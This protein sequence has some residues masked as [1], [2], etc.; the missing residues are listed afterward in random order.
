MLVHTIRPTYIVI[1]SQDWI[2]DTVS[3]MACSGPVIS[4]ISHAIIAING[5]SRQPRDYLTAMSGNALSNIF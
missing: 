1:A 3:P 5:N 4:I 2:A